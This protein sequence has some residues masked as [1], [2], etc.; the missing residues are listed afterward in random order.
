MTLA[1]N[2]SI[3]FSHPEFTRGHV[4]SALPFSGQFCEAFITTLLFC[5]ISP[6]AFEEKIASEAMKPK[7]SISQADDDDEDEKQSLEDDKI[8][9]QENQHQ[10]KKN[11]DTV[12]SSQL[13]GV[14]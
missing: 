9:D 11:G 14:F 7:V 4:S 8:V 3:L 12:I 1:K 6:K 13:L 5:R 10:V 2:E